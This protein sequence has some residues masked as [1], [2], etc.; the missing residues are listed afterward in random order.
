MIGGESK[1]EGADAKEVDKDALEERR[2]RIREKLLERKQEETPLLEEQEEEEEEVEEEEEEESEYET[3]SEEEHMGIAMAKAV[4][5]PKSERETIG[6]RKRMEAKEQATKEAEKRKLKH[7]KIETRQLMMLM[8]LLQLLEPT[9]F[10]TT[11]SLTGDDKMDKTVLPKVMQVKHF[12]RSGRTKWT[13]L[14]NEDTIDW[15]NLYV[16]NKSHPYE[17]ML[18]ALRF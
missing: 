7:R 3:D 2:K 13:H 16:L 6:E 4:F 9:I 1:N 5:V 11:T 17:I 18:L 15:N 10:I 12:G 14:V 8:I